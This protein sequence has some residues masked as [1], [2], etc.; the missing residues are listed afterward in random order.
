MLSYVG[1]ITINLFG[2]QFEFDHM[3][4]YKCAVMQ[5]F[6]KVKKK[7]EVLDDD[8]EIKIKFKPGEDNIKIDT[9]KIP[10]MVLDESVS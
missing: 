3:R 9:L 10:D 4:T 6:D 2:A 5:D 1:H 7:A 8:D